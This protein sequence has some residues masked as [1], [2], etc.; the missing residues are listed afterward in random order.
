MPH[1]D[2]Q[3]SETKPWRCYS[4]IVDDLVSNWMDE[5]EQKYKE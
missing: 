2:I 1:C 5:K 4:T 3:H